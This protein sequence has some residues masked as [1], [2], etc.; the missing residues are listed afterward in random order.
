MPDATLF[1]KKELF[2][3]PAGAGR[4]GDDAAGLTGTVWF[5]MTTAVAG[6]ASGVA[7]TDVC[8]ATNI[9]SEDVVAVEEGVPVVV[10]LG[11]DDVGVPVPVLVVEEE[12]P[13]LGVGVGVAFAGS[14]ALVGVGKVGVGVVGVLFGGRGF[15]GG[16][17]GT[18]NMGP[19]PSTICLRTRP[20]IGAFAKDIV[21][22]R[23]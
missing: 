22:E 1:S 19:T 23:Q 16:T 7:G 10:L 11:V 15:K 9:V 12:V 18:S 5:S 6:L 4:T 13:L 14:S 17:S 21:R 20:A 8:W 2:A 3:A